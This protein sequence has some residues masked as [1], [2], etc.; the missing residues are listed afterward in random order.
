MHS[1]IHSCIHFFNS[2]INSFISSFI[3]S[4]FL[5]LSRSSVQSCMQACKHSLRQSQSGVCGVRAPSQVHQSMHLLILHAFL[6]LHIA[7]CIC[8]CVCMH[9]CMYVCTYVCMYT[10]ITPANNRSTCILIQQ[11]GMCLHTYM[12][13]CLPYW[14][15]P[16]TDKFKP[17][18]LN[19][20]GT[21]LATS[22]KS[23]D[24]RQIR[25]GRYVRQAFR[26]SFGG[27]GVHGL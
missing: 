4:F 7:L 15:D 12:P 11:M 17:E 13:T 20:T 14:G 10:Y 22:P 3:H 1:F 24:G 5:S 25:I 6:R 19:L 2:F 18:T 21:G 9:A 8:V 23:E 26:L 16:R 27:V